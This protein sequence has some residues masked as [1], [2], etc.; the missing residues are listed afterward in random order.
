VVEPDAE[1]ILNTLN[2][3]YDDFNMVNKAAK[4]NLNV[5]KKET[6]TVLIKE[7]A[8]SFYR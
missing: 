2:D 3:V 6:E 8:K 7:I 1:A 5:L 4:I